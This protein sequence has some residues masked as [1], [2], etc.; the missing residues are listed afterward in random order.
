M[1]IEIDDPITKTLIDQGNLLVQAGLPTKAVGFFQRALA[2]GEQRVL[3][4]LGLS[5]LSAGRAENAEEIFRQGMLSGDKNCTYELALLLDDSD[6]PDEAIELQRSLAK[7][8]YAEAILVLAWHEKEGGRL[9][10]AMEML[11]SLMHLNDQTGDTAAGM[12][13]Y[14]LYVR[15][16][17]TEAEPLLRR[18]SMVYE[19]AL[20]A[21]VDLLTNSNRTQEAIDILTRASL[22]GVE[23][24]DELLRNID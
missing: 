24:A 13:G 23:G 21:L 9:D 7:L 10:L 8:G 15:G 19:S 3:L 6:R 12:A 14:E 5:L 4:N 20:R 1:E 16:N 11:S 22:N 18:A 17:S 2:R